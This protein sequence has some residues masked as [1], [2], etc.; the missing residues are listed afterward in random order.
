VR[1]RC[2]KGFTLI[3]VIAVVLLISMIGH[4]TFFFIV[5][6]VSGY[7]LARESAELTEKVAMALLR[8]TTEVSQEMKD[9]V[10]TGTT[11]GSG[12]N[13]MKYAITSAPDTAQYRHLALHGSGARRSIILTEGNSYTADARTNDVLLNN[14]AAFN[15][16]FT[17]ADG[18]TW[19]EASDF[20]ELARISIAISVFRSDTANEREL[21]SLTVKPSHLEELL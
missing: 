7:A 11:T 18:N 4:F 21:F 9:I 17:D 16:V 3:E 20:S 8:F 10:L 5:S 2:G 12:T 15:L 19:T 1:K 13:Y 14:V 6:S